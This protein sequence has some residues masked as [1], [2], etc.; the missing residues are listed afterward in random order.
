LSLKRNRKHNTLPTILTFDTILGMDKA[1]EFG[2]KL[3][4]VIREGGKK[5]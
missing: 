3:S 2:T 1:H 4:D 5:K